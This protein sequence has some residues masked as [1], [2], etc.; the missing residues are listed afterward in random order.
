MLKR[1]RGHLVFGWLGLVRGDMARG[2]RAVRGF[3][4]DGDPDAVLPELGVG[5]TLLLRYDLGLYASALGDPMLA[6]RSLQGHVSLAEPDPRQHTTGLRTGA[7]VRRL[8]GE[9]DEAQRMVRQALA[10]AAAHSDHVER[11]L[12]L[13]GA[14]A[15][16]LGEVD[17]A[18]RCFA[19]AAAIEPNRLYRRGL[20]EAEH[21]VDLGRLQEATAL[22]VRNREACLARNWAGHVSHCDVVLGLCYAAKQPERARQHLE[23]ARRWAYQSGEVEAQLRCFELELRLSKDEQRQ[24]VLERAQELAQASGYRR[25]VWRWSA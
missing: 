2:L 25:F 11:N 17:E 15:H 13:L 12:G 14:I 8:C 3:F 21:L 4:V 20:W 22:T 10:V 5:R 24:A 23:G 1:R 18:A 9:F 16:D 7:Y 6:L 19:E